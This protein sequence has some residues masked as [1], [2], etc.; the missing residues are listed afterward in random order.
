MVSWSTCWIF[1]IQTSL[2]W[3]K[4]FIITPSLRYLVAAL[5]SL[6]YFS[7][8]RQL[9]MNIMYY[10]LIFSWLTILLLSIFGFP[11][12]NFF[13]FFLLQLHIQ[14]ISCLDYLYSSTLA[15]LS[16]LVSFPV[17]NLLQG[18]SWLMMI[19]LNL[20]QCAQFFLW[21]TNFARGDTAQM[22][23]ASQYFISLLFEGFVFYVR[24]MLYERLGG[25]LDVL[26]A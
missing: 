13:S 6:P 20:D 22:F 7:L 16:V 5:V 23:L 15:I 8:N 12:C 19:R 11:F 24:A 17:I 3:C 9:S 26:T 21:S 14:L 10:I 1:N 25:L 18:F 4:S 2:F